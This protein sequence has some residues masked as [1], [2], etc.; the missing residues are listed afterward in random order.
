VS[1]ALVIQHATCLRHI[2]LS[3]VACLALPYISILS[4][5]QGDHWGKVI[6]RTMCVF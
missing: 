3:S 1:V 4:H 2:V 6:E 5:K